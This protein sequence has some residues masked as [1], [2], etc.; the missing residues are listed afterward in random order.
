MADCNTVFVP[1]PS[2]CQSS[3][4][5]SCTP[6]PSS[7]LL[8]V[9]QLLV[10]PR[11]SSFLGAFQTSQHAHVREHTGRMDGTAEA[12]QPFCSIS[13][14]IW[15]NSSGTVFHVPLPQELNFYLINLCWAL[16]YLPRCVSMMSGGCSNRATVTRWHQAAT[17][18]ILS[19][20][21]M[22]CVT[23]LSSIHQQNLKFNHFPDLNGCS[24]KS[25]AIP[26]QVV[27]T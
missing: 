11:P 16:K 26:E 19:K 2:P 9:Q 10:Y 22:K 1:G 7:T 15:H 20:A 17:E 12:S 25:S 5:I 21:E 23:L 14:L 3:L 13:V 18:L 27:L 6:V 24:H 8:L 4:G